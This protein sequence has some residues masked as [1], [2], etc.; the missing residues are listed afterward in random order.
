MKQINNETQFKLYLES[1]DILKTDEKD[2]VDQYELEVSNVVSNF[3]STMKSTSKS[4]NVK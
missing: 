3:S 2:I 4:L 1:K